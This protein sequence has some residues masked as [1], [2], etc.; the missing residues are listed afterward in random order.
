MQ[1]RQNP[2]ITVA[3]PLTSHPREVWFSV[4]Q[5]GELSRATKYGEEGHT[6]TVLQPE[7]QPR[8]FGT[9]P[10]KVSVRGENHTRKKTGN[11]TRSRMNG[12]TGST[13]NPLPGSIIQVK[14][15]QSKPLWYWLN[16]ISD[17]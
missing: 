9:L 15:T 2:L 5:D 13:D 3:S 8:W 7:A 14:R 10:I 16:H 6:V 11:P 12:S 4:K 1:R 17:E